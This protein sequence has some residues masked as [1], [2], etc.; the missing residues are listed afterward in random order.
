[1]S[2]L[3]FAAVLWLSAALANILLVSGTYSSEDLMHATRSTRLSNALCFFN[4]FLIRNIIFTG[5]TIS[6]A[7][8]APQLGVSLANS[9]AQDASLLTVY[10]ESSTDASAATPVIALFSTESQCMMA[11]G[12]SLKSH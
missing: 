7:A 12:A 5:D 6:P 8:N 3:V 9:P 1:M 4:T 11:L 10:K 2:R